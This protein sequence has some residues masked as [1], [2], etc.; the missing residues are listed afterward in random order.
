M[1][2]Y[3]SKLTLVAILVTASAVQAFAAD[4]ANHNTTRSNKTTGGIAA[5]AG[6]M[7]DGHV[8]VLKGQESGGESQSRAQEGYLKLGD[9]QGES[10]RAAATGCVMYSGAADVNCDGVADGNKAVSATDYNSSRSNKA[11]TIAAPDTD[12]GGGDDNDDDSKATDYNS[13]RSNKNSNH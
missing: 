5:P 10:Q 11:D 3:F 13:S 4:P 8:T 7:I 2:T 1:Q 12:L 6:D 9:I